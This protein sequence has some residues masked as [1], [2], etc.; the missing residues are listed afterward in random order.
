MA[1]VGR[2]RDILTRKDGVAYDL[3]DQARFDILASRRREI[4]EISCDPTVAGIEAL[5][6]ARAGGHS[7]S[8]L[9]N[10]LADQRAQGK[11]LYQLLDDFAGASL[12][13]GWA[14]SRWVEVSSR[15]DSSN[16]PKIVG[17]CAGFRPGA[18]SLTP[19]GTPRHDI[20]SAAVVP[21]LRHPLDPDGVHEWPPLTGIAMR[22]ARWLDVWRDGTVIR[23]E[24]GF[25]DS[26]TDPAHGRVAVHEYRVCAG[27]DAVSRRLVNVIADPRILPYA[28]CPAAALNVQ[29]L[30]G[31]A[32]DEFRQDVIETLPGILGC[33]HLNDVLRALADVPRAMTVLEKA[34]LTQES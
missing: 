28:E 20:Q 13:A 30:V 25:Q 15:A 9:A 23:I 33:T 14:W 4:L 10:V 17:V 19:E 27:I 34:H 32:V 29:R 16:F 22:R 7:R 26:S 6:G 8:L 11:L 21:E 12:V 3:L 1:M 31:H 24:T 18:S 2:G 5:R